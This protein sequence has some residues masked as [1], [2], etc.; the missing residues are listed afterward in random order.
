MILLKLLYLACFR[1]RCFSIN[2]KIEACWKKWRKNVFLHKG[3]V[4]FSIP[5]RKKSGQHYSISQYFRDKCVFPIYTRFRDDHQNHGKTIMVYS[6]HPKFCWN[7][8]ILHHFQDKCIF[9]FYAEFHDGHQNGE[10]R[11]L[12][13]SATSLCIYPVCQ[14]FFQNCS[15][16][17]CFPRYMHFCI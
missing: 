10:K 6:A 17:H 14:I 3:Q 4:T 15:I 7:H 11:I 8:S 9:G 5:P 16:K 1:L 13:K 12:A 2:A